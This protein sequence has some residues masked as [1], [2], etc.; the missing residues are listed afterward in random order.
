[1]WAGSRHRTLVGTC[2]LQ[3]TKG[4][5]CVDGMGSLE[6]DS[7]QGPQKERKG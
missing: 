3:R 1:M 5:Y 2:F 6:R 7:N 4:H